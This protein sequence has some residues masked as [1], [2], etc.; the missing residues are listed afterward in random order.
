V[1]H[2]VGREARELI[3]RGLDHFA[4]GRLREALQD[5]E[6][7]VRL[8]PQDHQATRL[9]AF[10]RRRL[11]ERDARPAPGRHDTLESPIPAYLASLT[12]VED[13]GSGKHIEP[14]P[15]DEWAKVDTRRVLASMD[16][17]NEYEIDKPQEGDT[18]KELPVQDDKLQSSARGLVDEC[19]TAL[20]AGRTEG[21]A[22]AA[23]MALQVGEQ[24]HAF[25]VEDIINPAHMLFE[26]AFSSYLGDM[27][28]A[29]IRAMPAED[30]AAYGF[31]HRAAFL[32]SRM[33]GAISV[34]DL[35]HVAGMPR[36]EAL[37][38]LAA[39]RRAQVIDMVPVLG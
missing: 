39:L 13:E 29:P 31:D 14:E 18:W 26:Q 30:L 17:L 10:A 35:L 2:D 28:C 22:L 12:A 37:R 19:K 16:E 32:M 38:L 21:A 5:W 23:E 1:L 15:G 8:Q 36:F 20:A 33:D 11:R 34:T 24:G 9:L 6:M 3:Q 7:A 25:A 27:R 4:H